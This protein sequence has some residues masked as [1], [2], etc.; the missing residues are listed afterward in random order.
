MAV[1]HNLTAHLIVG[2]RS[3]K[4]GKTPRWLP[5]KNYLDTEYWSEVKGSAAIKLLMKHGGPKDGPSIKVDLQD[6]MPNPDSPPS[7]EEL[8]AMD[9]ED[10]RGAL[11]S[12]DVPVQWHRLIQ[13]VLT[14]KLKEKRKEGSEKVDPVDSLDGYTIEEAKEFIEKCEDEETLRKWAEAD[15]RKGIQ[16]LIAEQLEI[17]ASE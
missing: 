12:P 7:P 13:D 17:V 14:A 11:S 5:G 3:K 15:K 16:V 2:L 1:L 4:T 8:E 9:I 10:L 6:E